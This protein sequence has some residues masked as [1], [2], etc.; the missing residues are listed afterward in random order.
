MR[1]DMVEVKAGLT[2]WHLVVKSGRL[3]TSFYEKKNPYS[4]E[5]SKRLEKAVIS[6]RI[7]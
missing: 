5:S 2:D 6:I 3:M 4:S 7:C 1:S